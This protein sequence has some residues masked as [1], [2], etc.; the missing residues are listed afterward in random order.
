M[1][2]LH[3]NALTHRRLYT[4]T[5]LR[6]DAFTHRR[7][8]TDAFAHGRLYTQT[9]LSKEVWKLNFRQ[10]G[11]MEMAQP[12]GSLRPQISDRFGRKFRIALAANFG[13]LWPQ[14]VDLL[15]PM[16]F[17]L[18]GC[19]IWCFTAYSCVA[20]REEG[21]PLLPLVRRWLGVHFV[22][23]VQ[24][25][26]LFCV[27]SGGR[28]GTFCK[29]LRHFVWQVWP[30]SRHKCTLRR[31][32]SISCSSASFHVAGVALGAT[33]VFLAWQVQYFFL[34]CIIARVNINISM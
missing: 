7:F 19:S 20:I 9:P 17:L 23:Q 33:Q 16:L 21:P 29:F 13:S 5:V 31:T 11:E 22:W 18:R 24:H 26:V 8:Y 6:T 30:L 4:L 15:L 25:V 34:F 10:Y 27:V 12:G 2:L 1:T 28:Y 32:C 3:T 14:T